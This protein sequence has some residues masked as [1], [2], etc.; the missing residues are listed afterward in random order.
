MQESKHRIVIIGGGAAGMFAAANLKPVPGIEVVLV[1]KTGKLLQK[2]KVSGGGRCNVTH[3]CFDV[4]LLVKHYPR[5]GPFLKKEFYNFMPGNTV[6]WFADRGVV[7]KTETDGR[8]FP[9]SD[10]SQTII[11]ALLTEV[12]RNKVS[13]LFNREVE[14]IRK[15]ENGF[16]IA[17]KSGQQL[18]CQQLLIACGGFSKKASFDWI[19]AMGHSIASPI[20]SLFTFNLPQHSITQL[21]G[22][23][24]P[25]ARVQLMGSKLEQTGPI[26]ITHWGLSGPAILKLSAW[27]A[28]ELADVNWNFKIRINWLPHHTEASL[29]EDFQQLRQVM[30]TQLVNQRNPFGLPSRFWEFLLKDAGIH[31][32][33]AWGQLPSRQQQQ[34]IL[35]LVLF[36][37]EVKGKT[38][39]KEEFVTA[40]GVHLKEIDPLTMMSKKQEGLFFAGEVMDVDGVTGG[41]NFQHAWA[42]AWIAAKS[43]SERASRP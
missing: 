20:P 22:V 18:T 6:K 12:N 19:E 13:V 38:G 29:R 17:F 26:L 21:M 35:Q 36:E 33:V 25:T 2:V 32:Q 37:V 43:L 7:L 9:V 8:M 34:L 30:G 10:S 28:R 40:G 16:F 14:A 3:A 39:Y 1:E 5:G 23:S 41:F 4:D 27:A 31:S 24:I 11:D 15:M 42:S